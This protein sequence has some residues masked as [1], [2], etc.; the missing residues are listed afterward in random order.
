MSTTTRTRPPKQTAATTASK[1]SGR[2]STVDPRIAARRSEVERVEGRR[3]LRT[4]VWLFAV[5]IAA[6]GLLVLLDSSLMDVNEVAVVG[7]EQTTIDEVRAVDGIEPGDPLVELDLA[8]AA[9]KV[10]QLAWVDTASIE[11]RWNGTVTISIAER[12]P[13]LAVD[14]ATG[15]MLVDAT[16][17]QLAPTAVL[18]EGFMPIS[19]VQASGIPGALV[20]PPGQ[21]VVQLLESLSPE[22]RSA[23]T[24]VAI[25]D[26][27]LVLDL[28]AGGR[29][30]LGDSSG[31][32][33]K[34]VSL[35]TMLTRVD[36]RC[37]EAI[38]LRVAS[39]PALTRIDATGAPAA[40]L[41]DL[42]T[43]T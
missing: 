20:P 41:A 7:A 12:R 22:M 11:R 2:R 18:P 19:G 14:T 25:E 17:R 5:S 42:S 40:Q 28:A 3:R 23:V 26:D 43:C 29:V 15:L 38:D 24:A 35:E 16:G 34:L 9:T 33:D 8:G 36:L 1:S 4:I 30:R 13:V 27:G 32:D 37:L 10:E 39:A 6:I 21:T 31:L